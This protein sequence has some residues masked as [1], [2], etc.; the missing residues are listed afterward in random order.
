MPILGNWHPTILSVI[1]P[2][3]GMGR[4]GNGPGWD[5]TFTISSVGMQGSQVPWKIG[6]ALVPTIFKTLIEL[7]TLLHCLAI[8]FD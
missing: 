1:V 4:V 6:T 5:G 2:C 8:I 3:F 7:V